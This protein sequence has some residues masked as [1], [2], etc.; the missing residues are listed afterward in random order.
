MALTWAAVLSL[1]PAVQSQTLPPLVFAGRVSLITVTPAAADIGVAREIKISGHW[2]GCSP[3]GAMVNAPNLAFQSTF[4]VR[5]VLPAT[6]VACP[7]VLLPYTV[8]TTVT[9]VVRGIKKLLVL[10]FDGEY[11]AEAL[12]DTRAADDHRAAFN[13]TGMWF[14]PQSNGSGVTFVHSRTVDNAVFGTWYVYD[15]LGKPHWYTIQ[16]AKW[17]SQGSVME[18]RMYQTSA[19]GNCPPPFSACPAPL[20]ELVTLGRARISI[21]GTNTLRV[22]AL[23]NDGSLIFVSNV[24]R[25]EI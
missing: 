3:V 9:P 14:D 13:I 8:T 5:M 2:P 23:A 12:L 18:G 19:F 24:I 15:T 10:N 25:L 21:T 20:A 4:T 16:D 6:L 7:A 11:L 17:T 1:S 22:E